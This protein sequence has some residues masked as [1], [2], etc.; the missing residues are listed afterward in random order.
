[1]GVARGVWSNLKR[2]A[3]WVMALELGFVFVR[4]ACFGLVLLDDVVCVDNPTTSGN[5]G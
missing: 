4:N 5:Q 1:M 3:S 2:K